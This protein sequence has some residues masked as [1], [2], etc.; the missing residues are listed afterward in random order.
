MKGFLVWPTFT[1]ILPMWISGGKIADVD[2]ILLHNFLT[3]YQGYTSFVN[4]NVT[5]IFRNSMLGLGSSIG[6]SFHL[7]DDTRYHFG[8]S[9]RDYPI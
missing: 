6:H 5:A 9:F 8:L 7:S 1:S 4:L 2:S 3:H